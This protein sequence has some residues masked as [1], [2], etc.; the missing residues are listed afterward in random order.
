[1]KKV[2][3][4]FVTLLSLTAFNTPPAAYNIVGIWEGNVNGET[5]AMEFTNDGYARLIKG[6]QSFGG[7]EFDMNG[8]KVSMT[9][10]VDEK[11]APALI[12]ISLELVAT[13][14][15]ELM[16]TVGFKPI[17]DNEFLANIAD[18]NGTPNLDS[19]DAVVYKRK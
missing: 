16:L 14:E 18:E 13:G 5:F 9:Y 17:N 15:K 19:P 2:L 7:K 8:Q 6:D 3:I 4:L 10:E 1:M 12:K 11:A